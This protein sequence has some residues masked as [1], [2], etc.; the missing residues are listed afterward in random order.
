MALINTMNNE[1]ITAAEQAAIP[2]EE[3]QTN[4]VVTELGAYVRRCW[5]RAY[6]AKTNVQNQLYKNALAF[7]CQYDPSVLAEIQ[8][9]KGS[10]QFVALTA[11][12]CNAAIAI[13]N[14]ILVADHRQPWDIEATP[15]PDLP[16]DVKADVEQKVLSEVVGIVKQYAQATKADPEKIL[17]SLMPQIKNRIMEAEKDKARE[18]VEEVKKYI[19]DQLVEGNWY[20]AIKESVFDIIVYK[21]GILKG[22]IYR[23]SKALKRVLDPSGKYVSE[24]FE[25]VIPMWERRSPFRI[26]P[27]PD[28]TSSDDQYLCDLLSLSIEQLSDLRDLEGFDGAAITKIISDYNG[29]GLRE[30]AT[31]NP[32][33]E[34]AQAGGTTVSY[35]TDK[36]DVVEF[37]GSVIGKYLVEWGMS[38]QEVPDPAK[39]YSVCVWLIGGEVIKAML[40][41]DPM[42]KKPYK[43]KSYVMIPGS[44]WGKGLA[45]LIADLQQVCNAM[46]RAIV[47][48]AGIASGPLVEFNVERMPAGYDKTLFP[49]KAIEATNSAMDSNTPA[50]RFYQPKIVVDQLIRIF[51]YFSKLA[52]QYS[53][54]SYAHGDTSIGGAG[55]TASGLK[56]LMSSSNKV[57]QNVVG[58]IDELIAESLELLYTHNLHYNS[59]KFEGVGDVRIQAKGT[60]I[61][62][63]KDQQTVRRIE[64]LNNTNNPVDISIV[65]L[66]GRR[67]LLKEVAADLNVDNLAKIFP[68]ID[69]I[70]ELKQELIAMTESM[71]LEPGRKTAAPQ[72]KPKQVDHAGSRKSGQDSREIKQ[73]QVEQTR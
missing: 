44:I 33:M 3:T 5:I 12:K 71:G 66:P 54:P 49:W 27:A 7:N 60:N 62:L 8:K 47:N 26:Y 69:E 52:D 28:A 16:D 61:M 9:M 10:E 32:A 63:Q 19:H 14:D 55:N 35:E 58:N 67:E 21:A 20:R 2:A 39:Y 31:Y 1:Q 22:P 43:I 17:R 53:V 70:D 6:E 46:I 48:N 36:I 59:D 41:P 64:F 40:N 72:P 15:V 38:E 4:P 73:K 23:K 50:V 56:M 13:V 65:G 51:D 29:G 30:W 45:E 42:G 37:H 11:T 57:M 25:K 34:K 68:Q 18:G 24:V